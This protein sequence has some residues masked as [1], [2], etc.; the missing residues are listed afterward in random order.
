MIDIT[1]QIYYNIND[2]NRVSKS[3]SRQSRHKIANEYIRVKSK[4]RRR[5][6]E[7]LR[8]ILFLLIAMIC[9]LLIAYANLLSDYMAS[10]SF[11]QKITVF[12]KPL[13]A[14]VPTQNNPLFATKPAWTQNF[15]D[16]TYGYIN[17]F[18]W[19]VLVGPAQN[20]NNE[21][22]YYT[23]NLSNIRIGD[24]ALHLTATH[25]SQP[26]GYQY[27]SARIETKDKKSFLYGRIDIT[28]KLPSGVGTWPAVWLLP[29]NDNYA[30][31]SPTSNTLRYRNGGEIDIIEAVGFEPNYVYGVAHTLSDT[32][33]RPDRT[34]SY[35]VIKVP[36][37][38]TEYNTY[39]L[40]W[41][42]NSM[43]FIVNDESFFTYTRKPGS[44]YKTWPFDQPFYLIANLALGGTWG[45][46]DKANYPDGINNKAL[47][48]SLDIKSIYYY[49]YIGSE[50]KK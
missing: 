40:L 34:G 36:N 37:N 33:D 26:L 49:P 48:A 8:L 10:T 31:L 18:Y 32:T 4:L 14:N 23:S 50:T 39:T 19:S 29:A 6:Q 3:K 17:P 45:G 16:K 12:T 24:G 7:S 35:S 46:M 22:Q 13:T 1:E 38:D 43:T 30:N 15:A 27:A 9:G 5:H 2:M 11:T 25:E 47:P 42:P 44:D 28:A 21:A 41:T 20:D